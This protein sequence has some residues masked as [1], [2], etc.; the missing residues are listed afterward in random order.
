MSTDQNNSGAVAEHLQAK[1]TV[2][3]DN[4]F[5]HSNKGNI[6]NRDKTGNHRNIGNPGNQYN[7]SKQSSHKLT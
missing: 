6:S 1:D 7:V 5:N 4:R 2:N 3:L